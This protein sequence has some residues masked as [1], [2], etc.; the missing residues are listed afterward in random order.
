MELQRVG[1]KDSL[2]KM[3]LTALSAATN[4]EGFSGLTPE[5]RTGPPRHTHRGYHPSQDSPPAYASRST[6]TMVLVIGDRATRLT[7]RRRFSMSWATHSTSFTV[8]ADFQSP[9]S[10]SLDIRTHSTTR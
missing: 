3:F 4:T 5:K 10:R 9:I 1:P 7:M 6:R 2:R 8:R